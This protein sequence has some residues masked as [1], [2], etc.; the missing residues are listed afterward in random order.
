VS[1]DLDRPLSDAQERA[2]I[3]LAEYDSW[4]R[5]G[6]HRMRSNTLESLLDLGYVKQRRVYHTL[7]REYRI[8]EEGRA[9]LATMG[10]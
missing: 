4:H 2:L 8:T 6:Y 1:R 9:L 10:D 3:V 7:D 5:S